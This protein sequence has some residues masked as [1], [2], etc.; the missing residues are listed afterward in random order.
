MSESFW[1]AIIGVSGTFLA[2]IVGAVFG[3]MQW[4]RS[5]KLEKA[6]WE[7]QIELERERWAKEVEL[8]KERWG[9][10]LEADRVRRERDIKKEWNDIRFRRYTDFHL[11]ALRFNMLAAEAHATISKPNSAITVGVINEYKEAY[12]ETIKIMSQVLFV[13]GRLES[14]EAMKDVLFA[15]EEMHGSMIAA[16]ISGTPFHYEGAKAKINSNIGNFINVVKHELGIPTHAFY[17]DADSPGESS[18]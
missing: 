6:R 16:I 12:K 18:E 8:E 2:S 1:I 7:K 14:H 4:N 13:S 11:S 10:E 15:V 5:F 9:H 17:S 3:W